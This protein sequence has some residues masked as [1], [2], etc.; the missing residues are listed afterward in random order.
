M[1]SKKSYIFTPKPVKSPDLS[2]L[3]YWFWSV[4]LVELRK[5]SLNS[6]PEIVYTVER[7]A[8]SLNKDQIITALNDILPRAQA[9]IEYDG[10]AFDYKPKIFQ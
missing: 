6:I 10:G 9:C 7:Y 2:P 8:A 5:N 1:R 3:D 4:C